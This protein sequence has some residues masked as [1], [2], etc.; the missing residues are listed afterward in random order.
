MDELYKPHPDDV[1]F[2]SSLGLRPW[3][4]AA[5]GEELF[6]GEVQ[7]WASEE[8]PGRLTTIRCYVTCMPAKFWRFEVRRRSE[9]DGY[10]GMELLEVKT[11]SGG[12]AL[13]WP[14]ALAVAG[15]AFDVSIARKLDVL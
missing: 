13:Y 1:A 7:P 2:M 4:R 15:K 8:E 5:Y 3:E 11:G 12:L 9:D 14:M 10:D 6:I